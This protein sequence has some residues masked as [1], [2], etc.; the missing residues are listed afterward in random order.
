MSVLFVSLFLRISILDKSVKMIDQ[1]KW[2]KF[3]N[4]L[5]TLKK[6]CTRSFDISI[7]KPVP[8]RSFGSNQHLKFK[9]Q[10][11]PYHY[12]KIKEIPLKRSQITVK[13]NLWKTY[14]L[15]E[16]IINKLVRPR[17]IFSVRFLYF[18]SFFSNFPILKLV[19]VVHNSSL[20]FVFK[21]FTFY[22]N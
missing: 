11:P 21:S 16:R 7:I 5:Y 14:A 2:L 19:W 4:P 22:T 10:T 13:K 1:K 6:K 15:I 9:M 17:T 18:L 12:L 8:N 3:F 20:Y